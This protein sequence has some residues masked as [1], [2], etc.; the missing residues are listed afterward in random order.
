M[1]LVIIILVFIGPPPEPSNFATSIER[2]NTDNNVTFVL[3]WNQTFNRQHG[4][5]MYSL[6]VRGSSVNCPLT[7][8]PNEQCLCSARAVGDSG[9][10]SLTVTALNCGIQKGPSTEITI[11]P[12]SE[13]IAHFFMYYAKAWS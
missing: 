6:S 4:I 8:L 10:G 5:E 11:T 13:L 7:C 1:Q 3:A 9:T 2:R 12:R